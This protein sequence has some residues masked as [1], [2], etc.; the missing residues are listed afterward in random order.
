MPDLSKSNP[1][2]EPT[3]LS[4]KLAGWPFWRQLARQYHACYF[5]SLGTT[6]SNASLPLLIAVVGAWLSVG[7]IFFEEQFPAW[8]SNYASGFW[9]R[10]APFGWG[11]LGYLLYIPLAAPLAPPR[12]TCGRYTLRTLLAT[13]TV[14]CVV[15]GGSAFAYR[16]SQWVEG[17]R[18]M[19]Q[20]MLQPYGKVFAVEYWPL[21]GDMKEL[22]I[23]NLD[24]AGASYLA[25]C[26]EA[27]KLLV[28]DLDSPNISDQGLD[29]LAGLPHIQELI[30]IGADLS[31]ESLSRF[32]SAH[33]DCRIVH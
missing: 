10:F 17:R 7:L 18:A 30:V 26:A 5:T 14:L 24:D 13:T 33:P 25:E 27:Q 29:Q 4:S 20:S 6:L 9:R 15:V 11:S 19:V 3:L 23:S 31:Q 8:A 21:V 32:K 2:E 28:L 22:R 16:Q 1:A 12:Q